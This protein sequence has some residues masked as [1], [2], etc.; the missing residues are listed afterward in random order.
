MPVPAA[1][2][3]FSTKSLGRTPRQG[4]ILEAKASKELMS[5]SVE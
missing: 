5:I 3:V 4:G 2:W 1:C